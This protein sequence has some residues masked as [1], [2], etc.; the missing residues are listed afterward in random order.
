MSVI[1]TNVKIQVD[2]PLCGQNCPFLDLQTSYNRRP[3][4][5]LFGN[6]LEWEDEMDVG[7]V[8]RDDACVRMEEL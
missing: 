3:T 4:C 2:G 6:A 8:M 7:V 5:G 1:V